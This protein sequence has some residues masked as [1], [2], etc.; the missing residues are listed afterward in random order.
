MVKRSVP[1]SFPHS[2]SSTDKPDCFSDGAS[3]IDFTLRSDPETQDRIQGEGA[4]GTSLSFAICLGDTETGSS[5]E[6]ELLRERCI[7][8][9][10]CLPD[11]GLKEA[12]EELSGIYEFYNTRPALSKEPAA[13]K[14]VLATK[15]MTSVRPVF[16]V[17]DEE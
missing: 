6:A 7:L 9:V 2:T 4:V 13:P 8:W 3:R 15:G 14:S 5:A 1:M 11:A 12:D 10:R 17:T 16:P